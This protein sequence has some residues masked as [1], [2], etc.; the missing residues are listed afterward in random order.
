MKWI[1]TLIKLRKESVDAFEKELMKVQSI[2]NAEEKK[3]QLLQE[4]LRGIKMPQASSG[5]RLKQFSLQRN[6]ANQAIKEQ[7]I[8]LE[9]ISEHLQS[10]RESL[11]EANKELEQA[12]FIKADYVKK[13][14]YKAKQKEQKMLDELASQKFYLNQQ[15]AAID[16]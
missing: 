1:D 10:V 2:Y 9:N 16:V 6:Y 8:L 15:V 7:N 14:L 5:A 12:K 4:Q 13:E 11:L 3:M